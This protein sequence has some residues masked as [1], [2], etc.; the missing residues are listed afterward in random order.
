MARQTD[1]RLITIPELLAVLE[2]INGAGDYVTNLAGKISFWGKDEIEPKNNR[3]LIVVNVKDGNAVYTE[4]RFDSH[5]QNLF[6]TITVGYVS[7]EGQATLDVWTYLINA[8]GDIM[9]CIG[10][11]LDTLCHDSI[12]Y[13]LTDISD[14]DISD[15]PLPYGEITLTMEIDFTNYRWL[16]NE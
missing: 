10:Q 1:L 11:N 15:D 13:H 8:L 6:V 16:S 7:A 14:P 5:P 3:G 12:E 4:K 9:Y 2:L